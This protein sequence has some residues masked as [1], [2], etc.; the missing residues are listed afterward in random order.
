M[1]IMYGYYVWVLCMGIMYVY[2]VCV[3]C[4]CIM[5]GYYV[6]SRQEL[7][8][9]MVMQEVGIRRAILQHSIV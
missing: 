8:M 5:Y 2:Y 3:L 7:G 6:C 4:M 1:G 9:G